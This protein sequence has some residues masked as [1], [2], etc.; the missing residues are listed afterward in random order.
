MARLRAIQFARAA[1]TSWPAAIYTVPTGYRALLK[2]F[3]MIEVSGS[4]C[5]V[6]L[7]TGSPGAIMA[8]SLTAYP[9]TWA[10][11]CWIMWDQGETIYA[12][13]SNAG[14]LVV[15]LNGSLLTI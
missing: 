11:N 2:F 6:Q 7:R 8:Y 15:T 5:I 14:Q 3:T 12:N 4:A 1:P 9:G 10:Q 13:R